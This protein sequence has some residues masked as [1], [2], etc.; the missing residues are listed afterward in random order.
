V[1]K[2]DRM[3]LLMSN[4]VLD[5][6]L[7]FWPQF[8]WVVDIAGIAFTPWGMRDLG[9]VFTEL[10]AAE[11]AVLQALGLPA[12]AGLSPLLEQ[13]AEATDARCDPASLCSVSP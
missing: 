12:E 7:Q 11:S 4:V 6:S 13:A 10:T 5:A 3:K 1:L 9:A 8:G 2:D